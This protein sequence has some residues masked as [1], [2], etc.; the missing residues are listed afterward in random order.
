MVC[1]VNVKP[2][3]R[4]IYSSRDLTCVEKPAP[5][6]FLHKR[7]DVTRAAQKLREGAVSAVCYRAFVLNKCCP[8]FDEPSERVFE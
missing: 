2:A 8:V 7:F 4:I 1:F 3:D 6:A 5:S